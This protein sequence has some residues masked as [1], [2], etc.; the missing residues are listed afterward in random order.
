LSRI[1]CL[2]SNE[3]MITKK[4]LNIKNTTIY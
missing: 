3:S 1:F 4:I 2:F